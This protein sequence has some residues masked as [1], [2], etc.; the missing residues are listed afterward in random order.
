[1]S[2]NFAELFEQSIDKLHLK[3]GSL[4]NATVLEIGDEYVLLETGLKS[5]SYVPVVQFKDP[6]GE[7]DINVGD[8]ID[9][10]LE[11]VENEFGG[12]DISRWKAKQ[13]KTWIALEQAHENSE[14]VNGMI[15]GTVRGGFTVNVGEVSGFLPGS[16]V[17]VRPLKDINHLQGKT[18][19]FKVIK[20]DQKHNN[21][22]VSRKAVLNEESQ[23][24]R[25]E[26]LENLKEGQV[27]KGIVK[28]IT[29]FGAFV[30][31]GGLDGLLH[32]TDIAWSRIKH[33]S[34]VLTVGDEI[35]VKVIKFDKESNRISL[36]IKQLAKDPWDGLDE[37]Y[38][39]GDKLK[40]VITNIKDFGC[41]ATITDGVEGLIHVSEMDW[42][43]KNPVPHHILSQGEEVEVM[44]LEIDVDRHRLSLGLKQCKQN[45]WH[46]Y[47]NK[48]KV[49]EKIKGAIRTCTDFGIFVGLTDDIDGLIHITDISWDQ[50][51]DKAIKNFT[52]GDK[53]DAVILAIDTD[54][55]RIALG[56]KQLEDN[57]VATFAATHKVGD[58]IKGKVI[59][60]DKKG[61][62]IDLGDRV[63]G[64]I[65]VADL[66]EQY[67]EDAQT[68]VKVGDEIEP[69]ISALDAQSGKIA[70][71]MVKP[72][73]KTAKPGKNAASKTQSSDKPASTTI[74]DL[75]K[76]KIAK[77]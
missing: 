2:E 16:L 14:T 56:I 37:K 21:I 8:Q 54:R 36:G 75:I 4:I 10:V 44:V 3:P 77:K 64:Y 40:A 63:M 76:E 47:A 15:V 65:R 13:A 9:V 62:S 46:E 31:I 30:D 6:Q 66:S 18:L 26:L 39:I 23:E 17:D 68:H 29:D 38:N 52:T 51:G 45:P 34:D 71:S 43:N 49:G 19:E 28:N 7:I 12:T 5:E 55:Q 11:S 48:H 50:P 27:V 35:D 20:I 42:I 57:P 70:L 33:P 32:I 59:D 53:V 41:F 24:E 61:A 25:Q 22:V 58:K 73:A 72:K 60:V 1:M 74:G 67:I 69:I